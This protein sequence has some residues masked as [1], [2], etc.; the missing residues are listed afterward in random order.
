MGDKSPKDRA[1]TQKRKDDGI[2]DAAKKVQAEREAR[3]AS[4]GKK[5]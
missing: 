1:K 4:K 3:E 5:G 2:A